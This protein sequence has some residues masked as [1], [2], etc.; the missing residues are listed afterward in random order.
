MSKSPSYDIIYDFAESLVALQ[1]WAIN[2]VLIV[3]SL[4]RY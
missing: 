3:S 4:L 1:N 2:I